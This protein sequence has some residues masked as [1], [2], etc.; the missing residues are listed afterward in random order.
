VGLKRALAGAAVL[1]LTVQAVP[2]AAD[3]GMWT[4]DNFPAAQVK[5][6]Y[7]VTVDQA[8]LDKVR[9]A[10]VRIPGCSASLV[11]SQGLM[12]TN[13]HCVVG[14]AQALSTAEV[15]YMKTGFLPA[16]QAEEKR[17][18]GGT[19]EI[20]DQII[21]VTAQ[22]KAAGEGKTG[23]ALVQA[24]GAASAALEKQ[25]CDPRPGFRCQVISLYGGGQYKLHVFKRYE[26]VR[27]AFTPEFKT[28]FF[29]GDPD[30]FNFPRYN[31]DFGL[32]RI[33]ENGKPLA[34]PQHLKWNAGPLKA[35]DPV[36]VVG[37]P[38]STARLQS[39]AQLETQ[40]D[41]TLPLNV[42]RTS[43][44]RGRIIR[45]SQENPE[46][47][48]LAEDTI[49][50]LENGFKVNYGRLRALT[51]P[52]F[53]GE[54][55]KAEQDLRA[56]V[57]AN[58]ALVAEI[59]DPWADLASIQG[60][61]RDLYLT[62]DVLG[63][64]AGSELF[65]WARTLVRAAAERPKPSAERLPEFAD[66][67]LPQVA[68]GVLTDDPI[69]VGLEQL[70]LEFWL[71]KAREHLGAD[72]PLTVQLLGRESPESLAA[73]LV[74]GT[75]LGDPAVRKALW[76]GG[77][78]A[79]QASDDPMIKYVLALEPASRDV[80]K[81]WESR[82]TGPTTAAQARIA[83]ARFA[84]YGDSIYPDATFSPRITY[85]SITGWVE[86]GREIPPFTTFAGLF[87]RATGKPPYELPQSWYRA[88]DRLKLDTPFDF[89]ATMDIIGGNSGSPTLN[90]KGEVVG[91]VFDGN[92]HSLGGNYGYDPRLNRSVHVSAAGMQEA[93]LKVYGREALVK[94]LNSK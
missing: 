27:L 35:G 28:G 77:M 86:R 42:I 40:R 84:V 45:F 58:P 92:I 75:R 90:A 15:D 1:A 52:T 94:E 76:E 16:T 80:R 25:T 46:N 43:E 78:A 7:G 69:K 57:A 6:K 14:C 65:G 26:D 66:S 23:A 64:P 72:D 32:L 22:V 33:Y 18:P 41:L 62:N 24:T 54:K 55:V 39:V 87:D 89:S 47:Y 21:D 85:G 48:R 83:K 44:R 19:A 70:N 74:G 67:R 31:L 34:T 8:W 81:Q 82:V 88:K 37:N 61:Y 3:E 29:G 11:S 17:C 71:S 36:F 51:D 4:F 68:R 73:R 9:G 12:L 38:G 20:L 5:A 53:F 49:A 91:V 50:G 93:L 13:Y 63:G 2:A 10:T 56:K 60:A 79:I 30:N 59:G